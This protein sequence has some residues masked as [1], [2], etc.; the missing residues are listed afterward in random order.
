MRK[1]KNQSKT[2]PIQ[3]FVLSLPYLISTVFLIKI[4]L[5]QFLIELEPLSLLN[6]FLLR[7]GLVIKLKPF[8]WCTPLATTKETN[9]KLESSTTTKVNTTFKKKM[10]HKQEY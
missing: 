3:F 1:N 4:T 10:S 9:K 8:K 5:N 7:N 6:Q 2:T